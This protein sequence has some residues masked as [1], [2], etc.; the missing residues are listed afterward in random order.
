[1]LQND[2]TAV[3]LIK[4]RPGLERSVEDGLKKVF[5]KSCDQEGTCPLGHDG[6]TPVCSVLNFVL[7]GHTLGRFDFAL[8]ARTSDANARDVHQLVLKCIRT[9]LKSG[10]VMDTETTVVYNILDVWSSER[11]GQ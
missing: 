6:K 5:H 8:V 4:S 10:G 2:A 9:N 7:L 3:I 11:T 1:M